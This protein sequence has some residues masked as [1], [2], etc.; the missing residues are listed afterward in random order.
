MPIFAL[1]S[2]VPEQALPQAAEDYKG[3]KTVEQYRLGAQAIYFLGFP[4]TQ[5]LPFAA[6][7]KVIVRTVG[8]CAT[9]SCGKQL[10]VICFRMFYEGETGFKDF[11]FEKQ[12]NAELVSE[13]LLRC[14]PKLEI[15]SKIS[16]NKF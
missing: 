12:K 9:G 2:I 4:G 3:A 5:Y 14:N 6:V 16:E 8:L 7:Q 15:D 10:P 11:M 1:K 13:A